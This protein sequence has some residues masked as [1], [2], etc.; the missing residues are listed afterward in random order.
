V[1]PYEAVRHAP[2]PAGTLSAFLDAI[3][4]RCVDAAGWDR[5]ALSY[6]APR[7]RRAT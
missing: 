3:Y 5:D 6:A 4:A 2:D 7:R 1:L